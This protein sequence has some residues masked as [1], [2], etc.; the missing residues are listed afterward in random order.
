LAEL[1]PFWLKNDLKEELLYFLFGIGSK[2]L[3][4]KST[5]CQVC[6]DSCLVE[7]MKGESIPVLIQ[8][9]DYIKGSK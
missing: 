1:V 5:Y 3:K 4:E 2:F 8:A 7:S 6:F 9:E